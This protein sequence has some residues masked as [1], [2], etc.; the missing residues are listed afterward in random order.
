MFQIYFPLVLLVIYVKN[1][2]GIE[3]EITVN[4]PAKTEECFYEPVQK[5]AVIDLEYQVIDGGHGDLDITFH[6]VDPT[7]RIL[8]AD[9]KKSENNHRVE[10]ALEGDYKICFDNRFS[11][12]NSKTVFF[13]L[14][15]DS[16]DSE[17][18]TNERI[19]GIIPE[20]VYSLTVEEIKD[21]VNKVRSNL[22]RARILQEMIKSSEARDRNIG[23]ENY[24]K[25]NTFSW[26]QIIVML[27]VGFVQVIMVRSLFDD[28]SK[29]HKLWAKFNAK[30]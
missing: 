16:D 14:L 19:E 20:E 13:E 3:R 2:F 6:F 7:G 4:I 10:A 21:G 1:A 15:I 24:F 28:K 27:L 9:Y 22:A 23:E 30:Y 29:V 8:H 12:Y 25:V 11:S 18:E 26:I 17:D 5:G